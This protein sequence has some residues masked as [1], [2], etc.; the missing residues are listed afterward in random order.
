MRSNCQIEQGKNSMSLTVSYDPEIKVI[1]TV[2]RDT[3][4]PTELQQ[5]IIQAAALGKEHNCKLFFTDCSQAS[6]EFSI[7]DVFELPNLQN[8][9]G[10]DRS[11]RMAVFALS[12][13]AIFRPSV[14]I[15]KW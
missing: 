14:D 3:V 12:Y 8:N 9:L 6:I 4:D 1:K 5:E 10:L 2:L 11:I 7:V 13:I 15:A